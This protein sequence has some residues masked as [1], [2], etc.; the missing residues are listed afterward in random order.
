MN[1]KRTIIGLIL[2]CFSVIGY[3][4][5][6]D[7]SLKVNRTRISLLGG[8][9]RI[10]GLQA[11]YV[12]PAANN[13]FGI[14]ADV[15]VL[16]NLFPESKT[17]TRYTGLGFNTYLNKKGTGP[18]AGFSYGH[19]FIRADEIGNDPVDLDVSFKWV[20]TQLGI[21]AGKRLFFQLEL[22]YSL[23]FYD[24][25]KANEFLNETYGVEIKPTIN[26]LHFPNGS[27]GFGYAF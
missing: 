8:L 10:A 27:I 14:K 20:T 7:D 12:L 26:F 3:G 18:Y 16:P 9:P 23:I 5:K 22:G 19:L 2:L 6:M 24:V 21:K 4:Q 17:F 1:G 25:D 15:S 13:H 11:E